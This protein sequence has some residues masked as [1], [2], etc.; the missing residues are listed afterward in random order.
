MTNSAVVRKSPRALAGNGRTNLSQARVFAPLCDVYENADEFLVL[1]DVPGVES[2]GL[3]LEYE[4]SEL[5]IHA[6]PAT[7]GR[8]GSEIAYRRVFTIAEQIDPE[9]ITAELKNGVLSVR[10]TKSETIKP[11]KIAV[12][13]A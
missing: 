5:R 12:S 9:G 10:L 2:S 11:R 3:E 1:A 4:R 13:S 7:P 8:D 6:T